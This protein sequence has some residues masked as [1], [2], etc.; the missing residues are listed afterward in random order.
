MAVLIAGHVLNAGLTI[1]LAAAAAS[2]TEH[3]STAAIVTLGVTVG[4]W[5][6]D[7]IAAV[8]GGWWEKAAG[9]TPSAM[10]AEFQHGLAKLDILL[11][12][13]TLIATGLGMAAIWMRLGIAVRRR[14]YESLG[15]AAIAAIAICR[16]HVRNAQV[17]THRRAAAT[18]SPRPMNWR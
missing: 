11:I 10:V 6:L 8:Q 2:L 14:A 7:F 12:A 17:G 16:L 18:R 15:L 1:A 3:P 5:I 13:L 9:Y 4:A